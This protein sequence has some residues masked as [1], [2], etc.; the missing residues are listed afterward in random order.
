MQEV[1]TA[2]QQK[3]DKKKVQSLCK[4]V[5]K[6]CSFNSQND[7]WNLMDIAFWLYIFEYFDE[8]I[9]VCDLFN[10]MQFTG[11]YNLWSAAEGAF[12]L[13]ARILR[14]RGKTEERKKTC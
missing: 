13:K 6:K 4:K 2:I 12:C 3:V 1:I 8:A 14:E 5:L 10:G 9:Q 11:N 7:L